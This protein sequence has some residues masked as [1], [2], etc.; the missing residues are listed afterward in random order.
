MRIGAG[1]AIKRS[2]TCDHVSTITI[3]A[4]GLEREICETCGHVSFQF[5][6]P[7]HLKIDRHNFRRPIDDLAR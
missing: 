7:K 1:L 4:A 2:R 3:Q 6:E 5:E